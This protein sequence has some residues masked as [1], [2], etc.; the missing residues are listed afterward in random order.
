MR[1]PCRSNAASGATM[2]SGSTTRLAGV[3]MAG[4]EDAGLQ[5]GLAVEPAEEHASL[6]DDRHRDAARRLRSRR[7]SG[8]AD[9][10]RRA[11]ARR[12]QLFR[13]ATKQRPQVRRRAG[14]KLLA[15]SSREPPA[16]PIRAPAARLWWTVESCIG[17]RGSAISEP[18]GLEATEKRAAASAV[19]VFDPGNLLT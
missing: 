7:R 14:A 2:T 16:A 6:L 15:R 18:R 12:A 19:G 3:R 17:G 9:R 1:P 8:C 10:S 13:P 4:A 11:S 5:A